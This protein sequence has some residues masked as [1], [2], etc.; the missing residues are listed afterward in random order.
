MGSIAVFERTEK[1]YILTLDQKQALLSLIEK[2][3]G[4]DKYS[5]S[6]VCSLYFDTPDYRLIRTSIDKPIYKEKLRLRSYF[7]PDKNTTVFLEL[8]KK[9]RGVVY[10]RRETMKYDKAMRYIN[11]GEKPK[12]TQIMREIDY[13]MQFYNN[14]A[15]RMLIAYDRNAYFG[16]EDKNLRITF[17][18][19]LR[20]RDYELDLSLGD[21]GKPIVDNNICIM[22]IKALK[23][24]PLWLTEAL[25][26]LNIYPGSFSKYGTAYKIISKN[27]RG[28]EHCA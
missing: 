9:Y 14:L 12:D 2:R 16:L 13:A 17:D 25:S 28:G 6:T 8:K 3:L 10:K 24:M 15:P 4:T 20:Y 23:A 21:Y 22:E 26:S 5:V 11:H 1:K 19:N 27:N 7:T 18:M